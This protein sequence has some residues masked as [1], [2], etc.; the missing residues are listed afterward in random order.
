VFLAYCALDGARALIDRELYI[1]KKWA[2][3]PGRCQA[4]GVGEDVTFLTK[5]QL[6]EKMIARALKA[7]VPS[8]G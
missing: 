5:P 1:P 4:A 2:G 7:G 3:D 8:A 6:A